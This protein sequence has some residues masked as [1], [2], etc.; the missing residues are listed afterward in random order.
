MLLKINKLATKSSQ[1]GTSEIQGNLFIDKDTELS[2]IGMGVLSDGTPYLNQR[3][4]PNNI[5]S[6]K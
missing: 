1:E 5:I 2:G 4:F 3:E 6:V